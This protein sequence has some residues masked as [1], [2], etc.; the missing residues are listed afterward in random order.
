MI[1]RQKKEVLSQL[2]AKRRQRV[3]LDVE[4]RLLRDIQSDATDLGSSSGDSPAAANVFLQIAKAKLK[5]VKEYVAEVLERVDDK[6]IIFAHHKLMLDEIADVL[7]KHLSKIGN[8]YVR[9]DG[10]TPPAKRP[11]YVKQFQDDPNCR[12][13]LLSITACGE[14]LTMTA[15]SMVIFAELYWVPGAVEQAEARAHRLGSTHSKIVVEF[16][17]VPNSPDEQIYNLLERKKQDTSHVLDGMPESMNLARDWAPPVFKFSQPTREVES[18][19]RE[20]ASSVIIPK[21]SRK[22]ARVAQQQEAPEQ[23]KV[24]AL[25]KAIKDGRK[26]L[27]NHV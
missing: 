26:A 15:A 1:R 8:S 5:A 11:D 12:I 24:N 21:T 20:P 2:P 22:R 10:G 3:P 18:S 6:I 16:L 4:G 14:G 9:I 27:E 25:L 7:G 23:T 19:P 13:A 17:V